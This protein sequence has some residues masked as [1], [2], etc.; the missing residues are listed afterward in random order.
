MIVFTSDSSQLDLFP[1]RR[2]HLE[3][4]YYSRRVPKGGGVKKDYNINTC[5]LKWVS[6]K[7]FEIQWLHGD[8]TKNNIGEHDDTLNG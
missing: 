7:R 1:G 2:F 4:R 6:L 8:S 5:K 3:V